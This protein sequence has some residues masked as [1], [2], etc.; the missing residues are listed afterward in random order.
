M[1]SEHHSEEPERESVDEFASEFTG[2]L[3]RGDQ[4]SPD[5]LAEKFPGLSGEMAGLVKTLSVLEEASFRR[6]TLDPFGAVVD[7][8]GNRMQSLGGFRLIREISRGGMGIV[9]EAEQESLRRRVAIKVLP[10]SPLLTDTERARFA[11]RK[12]C[13]RPPTPF[14]YRASLWDRSASAVFSTR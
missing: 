2:L 10:P 9:Y 13:G 11:R 8:A 5:E 4:P 3:R 7:S 12:H 6:Q 1:K 14:P